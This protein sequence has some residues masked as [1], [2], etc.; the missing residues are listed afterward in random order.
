M[1]YVLK[2]NGEKGERNM[3]KHLFR[4]PLKDERSKDERNPKFGTHQI[5]FV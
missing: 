1:K 3:H 4:S 2:M 5:L